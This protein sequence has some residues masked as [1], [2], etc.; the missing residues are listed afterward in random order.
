MDESNFPPAFVKKFSNISPALS[1][2]PTEAFFNIPLILS[3][4]YLLSLFKGVGVKTAPS[5]LA[6]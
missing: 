4:T 3:L 2:N 5:S 6:V 1:K